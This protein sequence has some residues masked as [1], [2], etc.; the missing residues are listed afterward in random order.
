MPQQHSQRP[1]PKPAWSEGRPG[2]EYEGRLGYLRTLQ[3]AT[4][5][6]PLQ[7]QFLKNSGVEWTV[8]DIDAAH[9]AVTSKPKEVAGLIER[10]VGE[11]SAE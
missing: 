2:G 3:D 9:G 5:P 6:I 1:S 10:F 7:D 8:V 4:F 11:W